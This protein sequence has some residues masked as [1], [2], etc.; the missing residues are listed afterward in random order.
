MIR[1]TKN[2]GISSI[3]KKTVTGVGGQPNISGGVVGEGIEWVE[4]DGV[5]QERNHRVR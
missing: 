5:G 4:V 3:A 2:E 1:G